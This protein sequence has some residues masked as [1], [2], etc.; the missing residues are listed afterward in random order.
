MDRLGINPIQ[1]LKEVYDRAISAYDSAR[2][3]SDKSDAGAGYL[4]VAGKAAADLAKFKHPT[5]AALAVKDMTDPKSESKPMT[6]QQAIEVIK[7][8][9]FSPKSI[10]ASDV[11]DAMK[12]NITTPLLPIGEK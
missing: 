8:D 7:S 5:L 4:S 1:M 3:Y 10:E 12:S 2:G 9:P 6:T 11:I